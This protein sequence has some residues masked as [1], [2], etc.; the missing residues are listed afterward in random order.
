MAADL[1]NK[2]VLDVFGRAE[3][4]SSRNI[5]ELENINTANSFITHANE[6]E[7]HRHDLCCFMK[8]NSIRECTFDIGCPDLLGT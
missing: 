4:Y 2:C 6:M 3:A 8:P 5:P 7:A 1:I